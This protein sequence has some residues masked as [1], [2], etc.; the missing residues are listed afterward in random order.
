[1]QVL[2]VPMSVP[3]GLIELNGIIYAPAGSVTLNA[4]NRVFLAAGSSIDVSGVWSDETAAAL[5]MQVQLNSVELADAY[6]QKGGIL[7]GP[8]ITVNLLTGCSIGNIASDI[9]AQQ[10]TAQQQAVNGGSIII[11]GS[12]TSDIIIKQGATLN[13]SGGG[14]NYSGGYVDSTKLVSGGKIYDISNAPLYLTY[15]QIIQGVGTYVAAHTQ[16]GNAG[17]LTLAAGT[18]VLDGQLEGSATRGIFQNA[19][20]PVDL[21]SGSAYLLSVAQ[22]LQTPRGGTLTIGNQP[23]GL[24]PFQEDALVQADHR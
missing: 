21:T 3:T 18:I 23:P 12:S 17:S 5:A 22:G 1:M 13:F 9:L 8:T 16:G 11:E 19:W 24:A 2:K 15:D 4:G 14:I 7:Q 6:G 10:Q 20:T